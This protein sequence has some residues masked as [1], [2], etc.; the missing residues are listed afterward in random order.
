MGNSELAKKVFALV[1]AKIPYCP[2]TIELEMAYQSRLAM[3][4]IRFAIG[5]IERH[6]PGQSLL[7][8][9]SFQLADALD[10]LE[11]ADR[12]FQEVLRIGSQ[13]TT[14]DNDD[15]QNGKHSDI[16]VGLPFAS[17]SPLDK[18]AGFR[19]HW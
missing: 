14:H 1:E 3:E 17:Q 18:D 5:E 15:G 13:V 11:S 9:T 4:R 6:V 12:H 10:R 7:C 19:Q 8:E 2:S 16:G